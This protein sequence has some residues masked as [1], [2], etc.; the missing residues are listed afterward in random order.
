MSKPLKVIVAVAVE[1]DANEPL[2]KIEDDII[3]ALLQ[4]QVGG[5]R[6]VALESA[7]LKQP[8]ADSWWNRI[9]ERNPMNT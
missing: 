8:E 9:I 2:T 6:G 5:V 1:V 7:S 3:D 4:K